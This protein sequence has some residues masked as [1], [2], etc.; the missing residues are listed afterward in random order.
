MLQLILVDYHLCNISLAKMFARRISKYS[1]LIIYVD[2]NK[3]SD[4][5]SP[6]V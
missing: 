2:N 3:F 5:V 4:A 6:I 1:I